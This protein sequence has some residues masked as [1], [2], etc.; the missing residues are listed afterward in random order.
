MAQGQFMREFLFFRMFTKT[1]TSNRVIAVSLAATEERLEEFMSIVNTVME[2]FDLA[3]A[4][5]KGGKR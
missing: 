1:L 3:E 5:A 4:P 2:S